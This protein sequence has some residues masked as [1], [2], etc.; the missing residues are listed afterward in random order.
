MD[1]LNKAITEKVA[2]YNR[3]QENDEPGDPACLAGI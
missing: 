3:D 1:I 2:V